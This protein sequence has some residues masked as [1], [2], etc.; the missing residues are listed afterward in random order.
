MCVLFMS[1]F[2]LYTRQ[3]WGDNSLGQLGQNDAKTRGKLPTDMGDA[4]PAVDL[5][6]DFKVDTVQSGDD[7]NCAIDTEGGIKV[8]GGGG[9]IFL[10]LF[11]VFFFYIN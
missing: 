7:H 11:F 4:L 8:R 9:V 2:L 3:C 10:S 1:F 6:V 5:G